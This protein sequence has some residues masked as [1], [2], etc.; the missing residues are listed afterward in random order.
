MVFPE[1]TF[2]RVSDMRSFAIQTFEWMWAGFALLGFEPRWIY[3][4]ISFTTLCKVM[5]IISKMRPIV[6][7]TFWTLNMTNPCQVI[8]F[9]T[10]FALRNAW[11][12]VSAPHCS[13]NTS[14]V[15]SPV[16]NFFCIVTILG[17]PDIDP[18][19]FTEKTHFMCLKFYFWIIFLSVYVGINVTAYGRTS[20]NCT[21]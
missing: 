7:G 6:L 8:L 10:I 3:F 5:I 9:P 21:R 18:K 1:R 12:H 16:D 11:V 2:D 14:N 20:R 17:I 15:E 4:I 19:I 13:N